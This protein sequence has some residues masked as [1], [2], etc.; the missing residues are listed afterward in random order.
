M[1]EV[2]GREG[3]AVAAGVAVSETVM[4]PAVPASIPTV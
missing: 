1:T 4:L 2:V 3:G